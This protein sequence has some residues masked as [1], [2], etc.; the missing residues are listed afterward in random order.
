MESEESHVPHLPVELLESISHLLGPTDLL[1]FRLACR[2]F[3]DIS[4]DNFVRS[5]IEEISCFFPDPARV[6]RLANIT[7]QPHLVGRIRTVFLT[8]DAFEYKDDQVNFVVPAHDRGD[9]LPDYKVAFNREEVE[10]HCA[11]RWSLDLL[12]QSLARLNPMRCKLHLD[13]GNRQSF[14]DHVEWALISQK[15]LAAIEKALYPI[16][17]LTILSDRDLDPSHIAHHETE[18]MRFIRSAHHELYCTP[19][20]S[21]QINDPRFESSAGTTFE[22][23]F[24]AMYQAVAAPQDLE[25]LSIIYWHWTPHS[26]T[27]TNNIV[28]AN[29]WTRLKL[30]T[31]AHVLLPTFE[32]LFCL[33]RSC[34]N[35]LEIV[36]LDRVEVF[37]AD[38]H[39]W[40]TFF[41][42]LRALP[43]LEHLNIQQLWWRRGGGQRL[44]IVDDATCIAVRCIESGNAGVKAALNGILQKGFTVWN[45][46]ERIKLW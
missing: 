6:Q 29:T 22:Q 12:A 21:A 10:Y 8:L 30:L 18:G 36:Q 17:D 28:S 43:K 41:E 45:G 39:E 20:H 13:F 35:A 32:N 1:S 23:S 16:Y 37:S 24:A 15:V 33:L 27:L 2:T 46:S 38:G 44:L 34:H 26:S 3:A 14:R 11:R 9:T 19:F 7:S 4:L 5:H 31:F 42:I 40:K 25:S